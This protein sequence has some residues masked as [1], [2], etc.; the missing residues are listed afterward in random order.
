MSAKELFKGKIEQVQELKDKKRILVNYGQS[1]PVNEEERQVIESFASKY[2]CAIAVE[3]TSNL[4]CKGTINTWLISQVLTKEMFIE[5]APDLVISFGGNY[6]SKIKNLLKNCPVNFEHWT[7]N[8]EGAV[9]DQFKK[10]TRVFE[11]ST[12]EFF[13]YFDENG[14]QPLEKNEYL[15][16]WKSK[17]DSLG[18]PDFPF[19]NNYAMQ[20][21]IKR[22]P[23]NSLLHLGNGMSVHL[24]QLFPLDE[25]IVS[26][27]HS[28]T[29]TIDGTL[30]TFIGQ[31]AISKKQ[32]FMFIGDLGF[33]YDMNALWN[34]YVGK[35]VRILLSNNEGGETFHWNNA[36]E[37]DTVNLHTAAEHF[38][39]AKGWVESRGFTYL[40]AH[41]KEEFDA[42]L[43][44][45]MSEEVEG[46]IFFELFTKKE[47]DARIL[48]DYYEI[49][50]K[51]LRTSKKTNA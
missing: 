14:G 34:R 41:N 24:A 48:L 33:F 37:I 4:K 32:C 6:V 28:S 43:P 16:L 3:S 19:S 26:Y 30:S 42:L 5:Y 15:E 44:E 9:V 31:A 29:T 25:S 11:C 27:C 47:T 8:E 10:L 2:N 35:N 39:E 17:I 22:L 36:R 50:K 49:C 46:P 45:F 40:S 7:V 21:L 18:M 23:R 51:A 1:Q 13:T 38:T 12:M 20:E